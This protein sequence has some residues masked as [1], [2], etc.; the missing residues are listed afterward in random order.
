MPFDGRHLLNEQDSNSEKWISY[1]LHDG[2]LQWII[3]ARMG[4]DALGSGESKLDT[5]HIEALGRIRKLLVSA[6]DEGRQLIQFL[7]DRPS[8]RNVN[9]GLR[10][11]D[12]CDSL[13]F[14]LERN[15]QS[16]Q[17]EDT[18]WPNVSPRESWNLLRIVQQAVTNAI[19]HAGP[20]K[21]S[22][23]ATKIE[24]WCIVVQDNGR[25]F[26][27]SGSQS[28][29]GHFGLPSMQHRAKMISARLDIESSPGKGACVRV[30]GPAKN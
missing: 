11:H 2:L 29:E 17:I 26:D 25:G 24:P 14:E 9:L 12:F 7:E 22:I 16:I 6:I 23:S 3:S 4:V 1:E 13:Q 19:Q 21:I 28:K 8:L 20:A 30:T 5:D 10:I 15:S 18:D 27:L